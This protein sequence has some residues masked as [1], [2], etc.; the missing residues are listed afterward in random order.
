MPLIDCRC[1]SPF[2]SYKDGLCDPPSGSDN[3]NA[4]NNKNVDRYSKDYFGDECLFTVGEIVGI[5]C[6]TL[7]GLDSVAV[8]AFFFIIKRGKRSRS[9]IFLRLS[10]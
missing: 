1:A 6:G 4:Y 8:Y 2:I 7:A 9:E 3:F 10:A 5:V